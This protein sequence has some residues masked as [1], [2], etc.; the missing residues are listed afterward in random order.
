MRC[1]KEDFKPGAIF[2]IYNHAIDDYQLCYDDRDYD[3][4]INILEENVKKI[5]SSIIAYC[6]M[7]DHYHFLIK[8]N[9]EIE[10]YKLFNYTFIRYAVYYNKKYER[11]GPIFRSPL[12]HKSINNSI[13]LMQLSK[14]IHMNPV[15]KNLVNSPEDWLYSNYNEC[16][17]KRSSKLIVTN[18]LRKYFPYP[19]RYAKF[20]NSY[21]NYLN[22]KEFRDLTFRKF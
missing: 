6:L 18:T 10:I 11:K 19:D 7:P 4:I 5:P 8:Q 15:R 12:Q 20:V 3:F 2:H 9:S 13:Y 16:I 14:Y 1:L 21:S 22:Q 17:N